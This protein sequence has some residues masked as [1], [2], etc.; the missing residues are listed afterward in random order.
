MKKEGRYM[1]SDYMNQAAKMEG[2]LKNWRRT[3][4]QMPELGLSLSN[5][6]AYIAK[7]LDKMGI[8]YRIL[9]KGAG[10]LGEIGGNGATIL[11]RSDMDG[12]PIREESGEEFASVN[13][14]M[15]ACGH[16]MH[17]AIL[18]GAAKMLKEQ[19]ASLQGK[20][21]LLFQSGEEPLEGA[22]EAVKQGVV[23]S[24]QAAFAMHVASQLPTGVLIYGEHPM[25]SSTNFEITFQ[26]KGG[27]GSMPEYC[28]D[29]IH[30]GV[31]AYLAFEELIARE[32]AGS[33]EVVLTIGSFQAGS[34]PNIIP[35]KAVMQGTLRTFDREK[36]EYILGRIHE[37]LDGIDKMCRVSHT[38][39][40]LSSVDDVVCDKE[41]NGQCAASIRKLSD[42]LVIKELFHV[43]G[44][45][46]FAAI[47]QKVPS[48]YFGLGA[49]V[50]VPEK[51]YGQ[52]N[53]RV[54][55]NEACLPVGAAAY[56]QVAAD[57]LERESQAGEKKA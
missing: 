3:L 1:C 16:D 6:S 39:R 47:S 50:D 26:G 56:A 23:D 20:V 15:H 32:C 21:L 27:H 35:D 51:C 36:K 14:N 54:R 29:P 38:F 55:F 34:A 31:H 5:T 28:I 8:A 33:D 25:S 2:E 17:A 19:E 18:L 44:S 48:S 52:H 40:I 41:L 10:I 37:M 13:G 43:M 30:A 12:L 42:K 7:E 53:P 45:E 4:H 9:D 49:A 11:L 57:Y 24:V 46:D 22:I